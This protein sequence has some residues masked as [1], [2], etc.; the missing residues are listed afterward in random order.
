MAPPP[1]PLLSSFPHVRVMGP[2]GPPAPVV[3]E[4]SPPAKLV[5]REEPVVITTPPGGL[6]KSEEP[7]D[8]VEIL[9]EP[10]VPPPDPMM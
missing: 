10:V 5:A 2:P 9:T 1:V 4:N 3:T 6:A 7:I 8:P